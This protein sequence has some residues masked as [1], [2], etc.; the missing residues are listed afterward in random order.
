VSRTAGGRAEGGIEFLPSP[1][2]PLVCAFCRHSIGT[3]KHL[4]CGRCTTPYHPDCWSANGNRCAI[5]G[6]RPIALAAPQRTAPPDRRV[7]ASRPAISVGLA[8]ALLIVVTLIKL[9]VTVGTRESTMASPRM[10]RPLPF[11]SLIVERPLRVA[12]PGAERPA[13]VAPPVVEPPAPVIERPATEAEVSVYLAYRPAVPPPDAEFYVRRAIDR[14]R[15]GDWAGAWEDDSKAIQLN[16]TLPV[17]FANRGI[18]KVVQKDFKGALTDLNEALRLDPRF[19]DA[20]RNRGYVK[21]ELGDPDGALDDFSMAVQI[22]PRDAAAW[23]HRGTLHHRKGNLEGALSDYTQAVELDP[24]DPTSWSGRGG[25]HR[26]QKD[27]PA[28]I[29]D[30]TRA[31]E[32]DPNDVY[33]LNLRAHTFGDLGNFDRA[34]ADFSRA[35]ERDPGAPKLFFDRGCARYNLH[36]WKECIPDFQAAGA[37]DPTL[38]DESQIRVFLARGRIGQAKEALAQLTY[39][40]LH[41]PMKD[42]GPWARESLRFAARL[43]SESEYLQRIPSA[44]GKL[45]AGKACEAYFHAGTIRLLKGDRSG[46]RDLFERALQTGADPCEEYT[47]ARAELTALQTGR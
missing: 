16:P 19:A 40:L 46:A 7:P 24:S 1:G 5:Y 41:H 11:A 21:D 38:R 32:A 10:E 2:D 47:S 13:P 18:L 36:Q 34:A 45:D 39:Y 26:A 29:A 44:Q 37:K 9:A 4:V 30:F 15:A 17:P 8:V 28:A 22:N 27:L 3:G 20:Y 42:T 35:L 31:L 43:I 6:C 33:S 14:H 12:S 25:I 23:R